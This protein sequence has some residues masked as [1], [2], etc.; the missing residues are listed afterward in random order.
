M[1]R[2]DVFKIVTILAVRV[3]DYF[4]IIINMIRVMKQVMQNSSK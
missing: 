2:N 3:M 4:V 1:Y